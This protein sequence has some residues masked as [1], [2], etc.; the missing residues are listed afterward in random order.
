ML[1]H[2]AIASIALSYVVLLAGFFLLLPCCC[3]CHL[4]HMT[5]MTHL[6]LIYDLHLWPTLQRQSATLMFT[7]SRWK[8]SYTRTPLCS[9]VQ[10]IQLPRMSIP[11]VSNKESQHIRT[12]RGLER[13]RRIRK[14]IEMQQNK[15]AL[16]Y[17]E[18]LERA[19]L[20]NFKGVWK[21][22]ESV[23]SVLMCGPRWPWK[24]FQATRRWCHFGCRRHE[25]HGLGISKERKI[26]RGLNLKTMKNSK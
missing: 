11:K 9:V 23:E 12:F 3:H 24:S 19:I 8:V 2:T 10:N 7:A 18:N 14:F 4:T 16:A 22:L 25:V 21:T 6:W 17:A 20:K 5:H 15:T 1:P 13:R 26:E